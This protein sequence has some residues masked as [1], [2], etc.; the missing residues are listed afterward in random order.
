MK[1]Y[2]L[3]K[4]FATKWVEALRSRKYRQGNGQL[5]VNDKYCC[6]GVACELAGATHKQTQGYGYIP[7]GSRINIPN[8]IKG[9]AS[10]NN[11]VSMLTNM[12]DGGRDFNQIADWIEANVEFI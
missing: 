6:L 9:F 3:P 1:K 2:Q 12:N 4:E 7:S 10:A 5:K 8:E 11:L